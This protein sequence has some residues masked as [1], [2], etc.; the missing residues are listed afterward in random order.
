[1]NKIPG[2]TDNDYRLLKEKYGD[3]D[4]VI[5]KLNN[6]YPVQYLIG[7]VSFYG[8]NINVDERVLIPR[9]ETEFL[10]EKTIDL[11]KKRSLENSKVLEVGTG[12]GCISIALKREIPTIDITSLDISKEA[13]EVAEYN[14]RENDVQINFQNA[15]IFKY[16]SEEKFDILVS[17]PPYI[18]YSEV[19]DPKTKYEPSESLYAKDLGMEY[20]K[21]M[22]DNYKKFL[23]DKFIMA[24]EIGYLQGDALFEYVKTSIPSAKAYVEKDLSGKDRYLFIINE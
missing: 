11:I 4:P 23:N 12:S 22:I 10:V 1:M 3:S 20:Y 21:Y 2:I 16:T 15:D 5:D 19:I 7:N 6:N 9:F 8:Y 18:D 17:N 24:F 13:L 14:A